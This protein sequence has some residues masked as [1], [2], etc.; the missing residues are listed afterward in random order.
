MRKVPFVINEFYHIYN[1]GT[2]KRIIF[3]DQEDYERFCNLLFLSNSDAGFKIHFS[4]KNIFDAFRGGQ[5]V[6]LGAYCLM[7]NHFH[8]LLTPRIGGGIS[9]FMQKVTTGYSMYYNKK[10]SRTGTLFQG[11]FKSEHVDSDRYLK[12]LFSYIHLNPIKIIES[13]WKE[14]G[15]KDENAS[16]CFLKKYLF[17]SYIDYLG[18]DRK[19]KLILNREFFPNYFPT[20]RLYEKEIFEWIKKS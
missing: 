15:I 5:I 10:Y 4:P 1:R 13:K 7:P 3:H 14:E 12:Y 17:S 11:K 6:A 9:K 19:Q 18:V 8:L 16:V 20:A 2:D